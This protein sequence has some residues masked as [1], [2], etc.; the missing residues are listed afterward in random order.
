MFF[1]FV[2]LALL[3]WQSTVQNWL[4][5]WHVGP[6]LVML[7]VLYLGLRVPFTP[8][9]LLV[10]GLGFAQ[11]GAGGGILGLHSGVF[12]T[13]FLL[14]TRIRQTLDP[15]AFR[16]LIQFVLLF[17]LIGGALTLLGLY[18]LGGPFRLLPLNLDNPL[19][20]FLMSTIP[21]TIAAPVL[22]FILDNL[23][24]IYFDNKEKRS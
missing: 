5:P 21:T 13:M 12:L 7:L 2:G 15:R 14:A 22:F 24:F 1:I 3:I 8:G 10:T 20:L 9:A 11:D 17:V 19:S 18:F 16:F 4:D 6:D 23:R